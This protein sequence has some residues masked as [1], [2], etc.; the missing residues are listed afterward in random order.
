MKK[1][2]EFLV[3]NKIPLFLSILPLLVFWRNLLPVPGRTF[4]GNDAI[5]SFNTLASIIYQL[6]QGSIPLWDPHTFF[7]VPLL[8]RP[9]SLI[10]YP[11]FG[12]IVLVSLLFKLSNSA[13]YSL[14]ELITVFHYSLAGLGTY[15]FLRKVKVSDYPSFIGGL[16]FMFC[17]GLVAFAS[18]TGLQASM[19]LLPWVLMVF[20]DLVK[21]P[22][23]RKL[24][25]FSLVFSLP[26]ITFSWTSAIAYHSIFLF[27][28]FWYLF[29][30]KEVRSFWKS[31]IYAF[32]GMV[33][34]AF[35]SAV[36][37]LPGLEVPIISTR[38]N[39][40]YIQ[41]AFI[42][43]L[44]L[45]QLFD[46]LIPYLSA[47]NYG[48][49][50]VLNLFQGTLP[51]TYVGLLALFL[52][53][54]SFYKKHKLQAFFFFAFIVTVLFS[55]G[56]ETPVF[57]IIYLIF[58]PVMKVFSEHRLSLY[59]A[60]FSLAVVAA[61][62]LEVLYSNFDEFKDKIV[63]YRNSLRSFYKFLLIASIV[64][65][66]RIDQVIWNFSRPEFPPTPPFSQLNIF[67]IFLIVFGFSLSGLYLFGPKKKR[68]FELVFFLIVFFDLFIFAEKFPINSVGVDPSRLLS[69]NEVVKFITAENGRFFYRSDVRELPH[70]YASAL[71]NINHIVG[72]LIYTNKVTFGFYELMTRVPRNQTVDTVSAL[73]YIVTE[74][75]I[76]SN[77]Y[78]LAFE[79]TVDQSKGPD[80]YHLGNNGWLPV[81]S[82]TKIKVYENKN[83]FPF[84]IFV[85][86]LL[87]VDDETAKAL[88]SNQKINP[89][90]EALILEDQATLVKQVLN[91]RLLSV[92]GA[93]KISVIADK[94][95]EKK[96][97]TNNPQSD[98]LV[99]SLPYY[100]DW[101]VEIDG[102][103][104]EV[105][106]TNLAFM[107]VVI[108]PGRHLVRF[109]YTPTAFTAGLIISLASLGISVF[110]IIFGDKVKNNRWVAGILSRK[111]K[112]LIY[113]G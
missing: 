29:F 60:Q 111:R 1:I 105:V 86:K 8:T 31:A 94:N 76:N 51:Y 50:E 27:F 69:N 22:S 24:S 113:H 58:Y 112:I 98:F 9:D 110:L 61:F 79:H 16:I 6:R 23:L 56:G 107:G 71:F 47:N 59:I 63:A 39:I 11:P 89:K 43:N 17:G 53:I 77:G 30:S 12:L 103:K 93:K 88:L 96:Y 102:V 28:Y 99:T 92:G 34:S 41:S 101:K 109:Y 33:F 73:R 85:N 82:G 104:T 70:N 72:Y 97:L 62:G 19:S 55:L 83:F 68:Y 67:V 106:R 44:R 49:H 75:E 45:R 15:F 95:A 52:V 81:P 18:T 74:S 42:G 54:P 80:Y 90:D 25:V 48:E 65:L 21:R 38:A 36:V 46:F 78:H 84:P 10:F 91:G 87:P 32:L 2:K 57:G 37:V 5:L 100:P 26:V 14:M 3:S 7:G 4:I 35:I 66:F 64:M 13:I 20:H 108:P 40:N